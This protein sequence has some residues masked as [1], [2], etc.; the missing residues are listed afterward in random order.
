MLLLSLDT[1][2]ATVTAGVV[3]VLL[4]REITAGPAEAGAELPVRVLAQH[5]A[6]EPFAH[7]EKLMPLAEDALT[8]AGV[9]LRALDAVVVGLGPGPFTGLRVG[10]ATAEAL[11]D[12]LDRPVLGV[13]SHDGVALSLSIHQPPGPF[14]VVTDARRKEVYVTAYSHLRHRIGDPQVLA[15]SV[16]PDWIA[17]LAAAPVAITGAGAAL[18]G[19]DL[20]LLEPGT[21]SLGL[22]RAAGPALATGAV[23][24]PLTPL[25]LRRPDATEPTAGK[26]VLA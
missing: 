8:E 21:A 4:P 25:Y 19:L 9:T 15:P 2:T 23:P 26:S 7:A 18:A 3:R 12:A 6:D 11:G 22:V 20:P 16:L 5:T 14:L 17:S 10:I 1:S 24:G 13:P